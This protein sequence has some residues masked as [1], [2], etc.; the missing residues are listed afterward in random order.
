MTI[1][2]YKGTLFALRK[3]HASIENLYL[4]LFGSLSSRVFGKGIRS[5]V[6][7]DGHMGSILI[8]GNLLKTKFST[9]V[10]KFE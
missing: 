6:S 8:E 5:R 7:G 9:A 4:L 1:F 2:I 10:A 3:H